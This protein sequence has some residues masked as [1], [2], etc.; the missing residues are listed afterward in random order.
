MIRKTFEKNF[1]EITKRQKEKIS[2]VS[3][4]EFKL[5]E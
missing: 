5:K 1:K 3:G 4:K 2:E